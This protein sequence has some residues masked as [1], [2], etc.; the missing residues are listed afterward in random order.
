[1]RPNLVLRF[2][3]RL[4]ARFAAGPVRER[5]EFEAAAFP[6]HD[7]PIDPYGDGSS[8]VFSVLTTQPEAARFSLR[9]RCV[10]SERH[11]TGYGVWYV[12]QRVPGLGWDEVARGKGNVDD[13]D[14]LSLGISI[15]CGVPALQSREGTVLLDD[16][17]CLLIKD[18]SG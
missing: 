12:E 6:I 17:G 11:R 8:H 14:A 3:A 4:P 2:S 1:M 10:P 9:V 7:F 15:V 5:R 18:G 13:K 16:D